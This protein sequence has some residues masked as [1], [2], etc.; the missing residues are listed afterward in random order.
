MAATLKKQDLR[1]TFNTKCLGQERTDRD[2]VRYVFRIGGTVYARTKVSH[3]RG[4]VRRDIASKIA[5]QVGLSRVELDNLVDCT[6]DRENFFDR[7][8]EVGPIRFS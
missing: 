5:R 6:F 3:G 4:D 1:R 2:H 7:L 8:R